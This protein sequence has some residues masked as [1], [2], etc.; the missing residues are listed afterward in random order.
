MFGNKNNNFNRR[1]QLKTRQKNTMAN[2]AMKNQLEKLGYKEKMAMQNKNIA[3]LDRQA[4]SFRQ[5]AKARREDERHAHKMNVLDENR[6]KWENKKV[7]Y[8]AKNA[9]ARAKRLKGLTSEEYKAKLKAGQITKTV[10]MLT[11]KA[12]VDS[13]N[14]IVQALTQ[15]QRTKTDPSQEDN[16]TPTGPTYVPQPDGTYS[17]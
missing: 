14:S 13:G 3:E 9:K 2:E 6:S 10:G 7:K 8:E 12:A 17:V 11:G 16:D 1:R 5:D 15:E 4:D